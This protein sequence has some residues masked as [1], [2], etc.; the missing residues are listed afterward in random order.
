VHL[1]SSK[2]FDI[3]A[4]TGSGRQ[5]RELESDR[6]LLRQVIEL[7]RVVIDGGRIVTVIE[8]MPERVNE[9]VVSKVAGIECVG[10]IEE[11]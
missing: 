1:N 8:K 5:G 2:P 6:I 11:R 7:L 3:T 4:I 9:D 10:K